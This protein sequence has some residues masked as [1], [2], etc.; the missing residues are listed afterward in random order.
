MQIKV[1]KEPYSFKKVLRTYILLFLLYFLAVVAP[2]LWIYEVAWQDIAF[3]RWLNLF[4]L[5]VVFSLFITRSSRRAHLYLTRLSDP[6]L[7]RQRLVQVF[8]GQ[9]YRIVQ[10]LPPKVSLRPPFF[11]R[12]FLLGRG[13]LLLREKQESVQISGPWSKIHRLE[14]LSHEGALLLPD[15]K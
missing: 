5:P 13:G 9:G 3:F 7:I 15:L 14:K 11:S 6:H 10:D 12:D 2:S 1:K 4:L 8:Q